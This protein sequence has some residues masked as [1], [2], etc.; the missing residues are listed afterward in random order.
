MNRKLLWIMLSITCCLSACSTLKE[1]A[2]NEKI[3]QIPQQVASESF[4]T[5]EVNDVTPAN[6]PLAQRSV[7]F[8]FDSSVIRAADQLIIDHHATYLKKQSQVHLKLEGNT[9]SRGSREYNLAL[10][11]RRAESVRQALILLGVNPEQLEAISFGMEKLRKLGT[12][13]ADHAENRRVDMDY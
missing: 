11:Q 12:T 7:Y 10:G 2:K 3:S 13:E 4:V 5:S 1:Q 6:D 9:D 8:E